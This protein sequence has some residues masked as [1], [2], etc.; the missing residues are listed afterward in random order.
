MIRSN[1]SW[2]LTAAQVWS[3]PLLILIATGIGLGLG[4][5]LDGKLGTKPWLAIVLSILG[6]AAGLYESA[7]ILVSV[8]RENDDN[9]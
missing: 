3:I 9:R 2:M 1:Y 4:L 5:W 7:K 8:T 6:L